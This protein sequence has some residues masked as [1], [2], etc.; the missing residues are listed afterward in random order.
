MKTDNIERYLNR[1][2]KT[3]VLQTKKSLRKQKGSTKLAES[4]KYNIDK[5][6]EGYTLQFLM[7][8]YGTF[9]DKGVSGS[10]RKQQFTDYLGK[11]LTSPYK[12]TTKGPPVDILSKWVKKKGLKPKGFGTGRDTSTGRYI[13][14]LAIYIS[15][16]I[17]LYGIKSLSFFQKPLGRNLKLFSR[18]LL[19]SFS[20]DII[21]EIATGTASIKTK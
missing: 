18:E 7:D 5:T 17:K 15:R 12:Y 16:K 19:N 13:S 14:G 21:N 8:D 2:G 20:E 9:L 11:T 1:I 10:K 6:K 4:I 3:V